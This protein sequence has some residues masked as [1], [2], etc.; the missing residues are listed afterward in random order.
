[1]K[2]HQEVSPRRGLADRGY[3]RT[4]LSK[5]RN[6]ITQRPSVPQLT[7]IK[8]PRDG[9]LP[10]EMVRM[11]QI[12]STLH[13]EVERALG[14]L[15]VLLLLVAWYRSGKRSMKEKQTLIPCQIVQSLHTTLHQLSLEITAITE[16]PTLD[17]LHGLSGPCFSTTHRKAPLAL[18]GRCGRLVSVT[19]P[20]L[21]IIRSSMA[22]TMWWTPLLLLLLLS[23][24]YGDTSEY[25]DQTILPMPQGGSFPAPYNNLQLPGVLSYLISTKSVIERKGTDPGVEPFVKARVFLGNSVF[26]GVRS[27]L[28][29]CALSSPFCLP[30]PFF[31]HIVR[32]LT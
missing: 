10:Q 5:S 8:K 2:S 17:A 7:V 27:A 21:G 11:N 1:M 30:F 9:V 24:A 29:S 28:L 18:G 13:I 26:A 15:K 4:N 25:L 6:P 14:R 19:F 3:Y 12:I 31:F 20:S 22:Y 23:A 16:G 32:V